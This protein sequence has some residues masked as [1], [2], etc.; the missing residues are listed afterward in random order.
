M[1][2]GKRAREQ[3]VA[4]SKRPHIEFARPLAPESCPPEIAPVTDDLHMTVSEYAYTPS[5]V[6]WRVKLR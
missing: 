3:I 2:N 5:L 6:A 1:D 4:R